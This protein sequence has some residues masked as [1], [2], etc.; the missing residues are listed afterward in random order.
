[1]LRFIG[2]QFRKPSGF[3]GRI[4]SVIMRN[5]NGVAYEKIIPELQ[6]KKDERILEIG[7]GHGLGIDL[8]CSNYDCFVSGVDFS[9]LMYNEATKRNK[10]HI[11]QNKAELRH[12]DYMDS[13]TFA[14]QYNKVFCINVVYFWNSLMEPFSKIHAEL[15]EEGIFCI[16]MA[17]PNDLKK[18]K[19][20]KDDI[21]NKY[22]I[23]QVVECLRQS[24]FREINYR[25]D[26]GYLI[27]CRK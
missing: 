22:T 21:F 14:D 12:G 27:I 13:E 10:N 23:E 11:V 19:F 1:M 7:Y 24:G 16:Y 5:G 17:H 3:F 15:K 26:H 25:F 9:E 20:T 4:I 8:I 6:I 2:N 18:M